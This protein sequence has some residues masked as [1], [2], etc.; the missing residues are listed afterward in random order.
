MR[1]ADFRH[2]IELPVRWGDMDA[3][4]HVNNVQYMRYLESGRVAYIGDVLGIAT[5]ARENIVLADIHCTFLQQLRYPVTVEVATRV[6][7]LGNSS[8]QIVFAIYRRGE[9]QP[10]LTGEGIL[11]WFDFVNE[12]PIPLPELARSAICRFEAIPPQACAG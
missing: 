11:V 12:K 10:V 2:F 3:F 1:R 9:E 7:R 4:G 6:A 5:E 8:L